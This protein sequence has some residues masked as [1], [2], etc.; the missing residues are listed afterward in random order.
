MNRLKFFLIAAVSIGLFFTMDRPATAGQSLPQRVISLSPIITE[1]IY[2]VGAQDRLIAD[3]NYCNSPPEA[4]LKEKIGSVTRMNVE[5]I[6]RLRPDL[7]IA[8]ALTSEKQLMILESQSIPI[9]KSENPKTFKQMCEMTLNIGERLGHGN[10][11]REIVEKAEKEAGRILELTRDLKKPRVFMQIGLKP[12]HSANKEMFIN[13]YIRYTGGRNIAENESSGIY[14][15][16]KVL[17]ENPQIILIATMGSSKKAGELEKQRW[18]AFKAMEAVQS[19]RVY[20]LDPELICS[21]TPMTFVNGL[22]VILPLVHPH[23]TDSTAIRLHPVQG[24]AVLD[25]SKI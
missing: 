4:Q 22:K 5:K 23:L 2:L 21:P 13:E 18:M 8:S 11:A 24:E 6:I 17:A 14:S 9:F 15:R 16:E 3:T 7:V 12:L 10:Q 1:T 25:S 19:R 20:V